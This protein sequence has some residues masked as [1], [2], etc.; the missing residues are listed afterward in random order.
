MGRPYVLVDLKCPICGKTGQA[1]VFISAGES[2]P[3][4][5]KDFELRRDVKKV[6]QIR[7][8]RCGSDVCRLS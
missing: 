6:W 8:I 5:T 1:K 2:R 4:V 3:E 7:C